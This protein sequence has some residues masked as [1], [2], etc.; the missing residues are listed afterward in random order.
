MPSVTR[1]TIS[2][3]GRLW[4][5]RIL[6][7]LMSV[8]AVSLLIAAPATVLADNW[9]MAGI[10]IVLCEFIVLAGAL[11]WLAQLIFAPER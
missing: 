6:A 1:Q 5:L 3:S 4:I 7:G 2:T 11:T 8:V 9:S 10:S